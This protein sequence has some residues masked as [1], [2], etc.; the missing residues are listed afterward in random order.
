M[1]CIDLDQ[2]SV[3]VLYAC[4]VIGEQV[5]WMYVCDLCMR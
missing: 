5:E 4:M 3:V 1:M 2:V